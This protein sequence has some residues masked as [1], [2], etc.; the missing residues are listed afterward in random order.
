M[1]IGLHEL[2]AQIVDQ[3]DRSIEHIPCL[4]HVLQ[5]TVCFTAKSFCRFS[6]TLFFYLNLRKYEITVKS[7]PN[8]AQYT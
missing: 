8:Y 7:F 2:G 4:K 5:K 1:T 3:I 6:K